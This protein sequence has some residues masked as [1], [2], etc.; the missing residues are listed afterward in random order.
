[1]L[2]ITII[3]EFDGDEAEWEAAINGFIK[4]IDDDTELGGRFNYRVNKAREGNRRI[5]WGWWDKPETVQLLQSRD[6][7]KQFA[8]TLKDLAGGT[9]ETTPIGVYAGTSGS[10]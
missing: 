10:S 7:F 2:G 4:S 5:H 8:A 1:M 6:Y 3:Y 9:L